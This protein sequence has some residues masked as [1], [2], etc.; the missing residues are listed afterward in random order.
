MRGYWVMLF[1]C[2]TILL[3]AQ[4]RPEVEFVT[5]PWEPY[6]GQDLPFGGAFVEITRAAFE[7]AGYDFDIRFMPWEQALNETAMGMHDGLLAGSWSQD[8]EEAFIFSKPYYQVTNQFFCLRSANI[9]WQ[10]LEDLRRYRIA[11]VSGYAVGEPFDSAGYLNKIFVPD[12]H[13]ALQMVLDGRAD[14][15]VEARGV[16]L[17]ALIHDFTSQREL[18]MPLFP[19]LKIDPV[20]NLFSKRSEDWQH[21]AEAFERGME[22]IHSDGTYDEILYRHGLDGR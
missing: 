16:V 8:R 1:L 17:D 7:H 21:T 3:M 10:S 4:E 12:L 19:P 20:L 9:S 2:F 11:V 13:T 15:T 14:L 22:M 6:C 18:I 5:A